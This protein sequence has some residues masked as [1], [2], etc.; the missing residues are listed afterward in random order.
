MSQHNGSQLHQRLLAQYAVAAVPLRSQRIVLLDA[1]CNNRGMAI[2]SIQTAD[3]FSMV[4]DVGVISSRL[5]SQG[6]CCLSGPVEEGQCQALASSCS[7][8]PTGS[9][10][11]AQAPCGRERIS[12]GYFTD[13]SL[14]QGCLREL[15]PGHKER[16]CTSQ[17][18]LQLLLAAESWADSDETRSY[19]HIFISRTASADSLQS[20]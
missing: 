5:R 2:S 9:G 19:I 20:C 1:E 18:E 4:H 17:G 14:S 7:A 13:A 10:L 16:I 3:M 6:H 8:L 12:T 15:M 11:P